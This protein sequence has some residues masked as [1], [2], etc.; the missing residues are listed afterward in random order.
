MHRWRSVAGTG[1]RAV[2]H[3]VRLD[4]CIGRRVQLAEMCVWIHLFEAQ[5]SAS[6]RYLQHSTLD[7][8]LVD[9]LNSRSWSLCIAEL[10]ILIYM[11]ERTLGPHL[12]QAHCDPHLGDV[13]NLGSTF[14]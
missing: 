11:M 5:N 6:T 13:E 10:T 3:T 9:A 7:L 14:I 2:V 4:D 12:F 8:Q 1:M